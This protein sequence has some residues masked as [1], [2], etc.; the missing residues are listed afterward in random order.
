MAPPPLQDRYAEVNG[1]RLHYMTA[2]SGQTLL[3]LH[4]F[5]EF[6]YAWRTQLDA[7]SADYQVV[8]PDLRGY[9]LSD[10][11]ADV[12]RVH[13][14][15]PGGRRGALLAQVSPGR[16][17]I[18][19]AHDWGGIVA[20]AFALTHPAA[21]EKLVI[22]NAPHPAIFARELA[23]NPAQQQAAGYMT[24][25]RGPD[26]E[27]LLGA[28]DFT[29]LDGML[30]G[31]AVRPDAFSAAD[32]AAYHTAWSLP[33]GLTGALNYY[34]AVALTTTPASP[35]RLTVEVPTLVLWGEQDSA[36]LTGNLNG[37]DALCPTCGCSGSPRLATGW[38]MSSPTPSPR[39]S[40]LSSPR[41]DPPCSPCQGPPRSHVR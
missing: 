1:V 32:R 41:P 15:H 12:S 25:L 27:A 9:N 10:R 23:T 30:F 11:P 35:P 29:R 18:L 6:W 20:W 17:A 36:L 22:I 40:A 39:P 34:R 28:D 24:M 21:L 3:F 13:H 38:S 7:F 8:A 31:G 4:G 14:P 16:Q 19:I 33:G 2:G 5:P 37:L 26:A